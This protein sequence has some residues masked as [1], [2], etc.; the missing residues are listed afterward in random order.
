MLSVALFKHYHPIQCHEKTLGGSLPPFHSQKTT[1][2][3]DHRFSHPHF[4]VCHKGILLLRSDQT[5]Y[6]SKP[7]LLF[8]V[9]SY[10]NPSF[11]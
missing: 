2:K 10:G 8:A 4:L 6:I 3:T 11:A 7:M 5:P 9:N 1:R